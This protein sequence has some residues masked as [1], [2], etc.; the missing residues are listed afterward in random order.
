MN[1]RLRYEMTFTAGIYYAQQM[2]MNNYDLIIH[3]STNTESVEDHNI[4][5]E[6]IKYFVDEIL[7]STIFIQQGRTEQ[8][9]L[10]SDAGCK[11]TTLPEEPVDQIVGM[12]LYTKFDAI[13]ED[14][15]KIVEIELASSLGGNVYYKHNLLESLGPLEDPGWW[16]QNNLVH[17]DL[18]SINDDVKIYKIARDISWHDVDLH[19]TTDETPEPTTTAEIVFGR[20]QRDEN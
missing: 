13:T 15:L 8:L 19:W 9:K 20:F 16:S 2:K 14:Y 3:F 17:N 4:A 10:F 1:V 11:V 12:M 5:L 18:S 6:R 7:D